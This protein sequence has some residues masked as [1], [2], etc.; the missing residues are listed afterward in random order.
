MKSKR[1][2]LS[3][4]ANSLLFLAV[5]LLLIA[6]QTESKKTLPYFGET[7]IAE[8]GD[9]LQHRI[10]SFFFTN[11][12][13]QKVTNETF[14]G[15]IYVADFFFSRCPSICP[16]MSNQMG[17]VQEAYKDDSNVLILS[18]TVDPKNDTVPALKAYA[19]KIGAIKGKWHLVTGDQSKLHRIANQGYHQVAGSTTDPESLLHSEY[20]VLVDP[21]G[22]VRGYYNGVDSAQVELLI[23]DIKVLKQEGNGK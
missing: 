1:R 6:C 16:I 14:Q 13:G 23:E 12:F 7:T 18:H 11:Q 5:T 4:N 19:E 10:P 21:E 2:R 22:H 8:N 17:R 9:T 3:K 20:F 15:K